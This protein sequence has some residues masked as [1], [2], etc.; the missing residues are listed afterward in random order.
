MG[1]PAQEYVTI[2]KKGQEFIARWLKAE[3]LEEA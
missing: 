1:M 2:T 3:D